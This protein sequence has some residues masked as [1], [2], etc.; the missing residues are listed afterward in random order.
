M[1]VLFFPAYF[2]GEIASD[3]LTLSLSK[4]MWL[5]WFDFEIKV[6]TLIGFY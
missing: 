3:I 2:T 1:N 4:R 6:Q 5:W